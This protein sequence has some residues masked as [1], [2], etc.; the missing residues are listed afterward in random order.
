MRRSRRIILAALLAVVVLAGTIGGVALAQTGDEDNG[1]HKAR[2]GG[3]L[4]KVCNIYNEANPEA[5]IDLEELEAAFGTAREQA[6]AE[7]QQKRSEIDP[8]AMRETLRER[9]QE[10][11]EA[12]EI[13]QEQYEKAME[14]LDSMPEDAPLRFG[15]RGHGRCQGLMEPP[16]DT[17]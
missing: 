2:F 9:I 1:Q 8:E 5:P 15:M 13:T 16:A 12:G 11:Y 7:I 4:E 6:C 3:F 17:E 10:R 14:R